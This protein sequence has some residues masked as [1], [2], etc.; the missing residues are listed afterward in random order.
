[1]KLCRKKLE[2]KLDGVTEGDNGLVMFDGFAN[3]AKVDRTRDIIPPGAWRKA[4]PTFMEYGATLY[5]MHDWG[6]PIGHV[7]KAEVNDDGMWIEGGI[8]KNESPDTGLPLTHPLAQAL[9]YAR[10]AVKKRLMRSLS[11]GIKVIET[12]MSE[13]YDDFAE[14]KV[15]ARVLKKIEL[16]EISL[17]TIPASRESVI[18]AKS[19]IES[20]FGPDWLKALNE[21]AGEISRE[22]LTSIIM[23]SVGGAHGVDDNQSGEDPQKKLVLLRDATQPSLKL[24]SLTKGNRH[25]R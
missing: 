5:F 19:A 2:F 7:T 22:D 13:V 9:D 4:L 24:V 14:R 23:Q 11:V 10:M 3:V 12:A 6:V 17:V 20:V 21:E 8:E 15:K 18:A 25:E 1:M 16:L